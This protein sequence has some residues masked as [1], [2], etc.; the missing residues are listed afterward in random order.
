MSH[1]PESHEYFVDANGRPAERITTEEID[2]VLHYEDLP[3]SDITTV[4]GLRCTTPLRTVID[5]AVELD[6]ADLERIV[7][8]CL[9]RKLFTR[10]EAYERLRQPDMRRPGAVIVRQLLNALANGD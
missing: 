5:L 8:D 3:E 4:N 1:A 6:R 10:E 9:T 2:L 7:R